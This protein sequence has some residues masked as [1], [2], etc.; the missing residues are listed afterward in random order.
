MQSAFYVTLSSQVALDKRLTTIAENVAN[1]STIGFRATG[2]SFETALSKASATAFAS[3]GSDYVSRASGS[4]VKTDNPF[5]VA[6]MG[7]AWLAIQTPQ[8]VAY[9]RDGRLRML[10]TGEVQTL[11]GFPVLDAGNSPIV[12]DP[13]AG[14]P[15]IYR[16]GMIH[17]GDRQFGAIGLFEIDEAATLKRAEN[18]A[19]IPSLP[20]AA[21]VNFAK[22]G[23]AQGHLENANVNAVAEIAKLITAHRAFE[24]ASAAFDM[25]DGA[26]RNAVR[27]LGGG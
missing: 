16:D 24:S 17:Q 7:D 19:V 27:T 21:V 18:S 8:G 23:I 14:A 6:I 5:D 4:L 11:L 22:N 13:T 9:T 20:A 3:T 1:A 10:E 2:V 26:Q 12:L 15:T 25:M